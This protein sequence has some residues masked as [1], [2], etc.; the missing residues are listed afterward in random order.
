[1]HF[2]NGV[3]FVVVSTHRQFSLP[4]RLTFLLKLVYPATRFFNALDPNAQPFVEPVWEHPGYLKG[5]LH[6]VLGF[7]LSIVPPPYAYADLN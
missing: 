6:L 5:I 2:G 1:M 7:F 3:T 4:F